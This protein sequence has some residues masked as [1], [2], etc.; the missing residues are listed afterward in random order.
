M[1]RQVASLLSTSSPGRLAKLGKALGAKGID[2]A[3]T[4]GA[5]WKHSGP[6]TLIIKDDWGKGT[7]NDFGG[8]A[9]V[10]RDEGFPWL[11]FRTIEVEL[12]DEPGALGA[13]A[14]ALDDINIYAVS[15]F[16][17]TGGKAS[18]G[19]GVRPSRVAEGVARLQAKG[20]RVNRR[21]HPMDDDHSDDDWLDEWDERTERLL[22]LFD[23]PNIA[24]NDPRFYELPEPPSGP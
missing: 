23:D 22:D 5:E 14:E 16:E 9:E 15:V 4:G 12:R 1:H 17:T 24:P 6:I 21:K 20:F 18:V 7:Q 3:T 2:I 13:A 11:A 8:F 10:M 19:L